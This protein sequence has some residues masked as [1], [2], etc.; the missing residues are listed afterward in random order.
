MRRLLQS[1]KTPAKHLSH[2]PANTYGRSMGKALAR[3]GY[4]RETYIRQEYRSKR[5][6]AMRRPPL[7]VKISFELGRLGNKGFIDAFAQIVPIQ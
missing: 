5:E 1:C 4:P 7:A 2:S 6:T 3:L